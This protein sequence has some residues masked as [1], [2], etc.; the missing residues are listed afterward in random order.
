MANVIKTR[1]LNKY[2]LLANYSTFK[3]LKGEICIAE[4]STVQNP[5]VIASGFDKDTYD[6]RPIVG[7]KVGDGFHTFAELPW[8][9]AAAGDVSSFVKGIDEKNFA[10]KVGVAIGYTGAVKV[11]TIIEGINTAFNNYYKKNE[12]YS[13]TEAD[14]LLANKVN[15]AVFTEYQNQITQLL[16]KKVETSAFDT[17]KGEVSAAL[18]KKVETSLLDTTNA[19]AADNKLMSEKTVE[20]KIEAASGELER[21]IS[22]LGSAVG[23]VDNL[24]TDAKTNLVS[25]I[26]E[27]DK[28]ANDNAAAI[29]NLQKAI[30]TEG[31]ESLGSRVATL[32]GEMDVVQAATDGYNANNKISTAIAD[33]KKAG[34]DAQGQIGTI[35]N[36]TGKKATLVEE[37]NDVRSYVTT[38]V[39]GNISEINTKVNKL[40]GEDTDANKSVRTIANEEL[41]AQLLNGEINGAKDNFETLK[42][43]AD[44]LQQH[45]DDAGA[46]NTE[47]SNLKKLHA[48][49]KTVAQE[50]AD[51]IAGANLDQYVDDATFEG[52]QTEIASAIAAARTALQKADITEGASNGT[53]AVEGTDV[54]VHGLGSAAYTASTAYATAAQGGKADSAVQKIT[55]LNKELTNGSSLSPDEAKTALGLGSAAYK[56]ASA[57]DAYGAAAG[58]QQAIS[59]EISKMDAEYADTNAG[60]MT[61]IT[62]VDGK[63]TSVTQRKIKN[64]DLDPDD[65][66]VFYCGQSPANSAGEYVLTAVDLK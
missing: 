2:D 23:A 38:T 26:N 12:T 45:P 20:A 8:V 31:E 1:I 5:N 61:A 11:N 6:E 54:K 63:I 49:G 44:W 25:A 29:E 37:I 16:A 13:K 58:V 56:D 65:V 35:A 33:A 7:I 51:G 46:M 41:A 52:Y 47:I 57:F 66:F 48:S 14:G 21:Q 27:I 64:A 42:Q 22:G 43:L 10:E 39:D 24:T 53:I 62:Q 28:H 18:N 4:V 34:T 30:G 32:E 19:P 60:V 59:T 17:Y 40:I 50:V 55:I 36:L 3:P 15:T 9:Q